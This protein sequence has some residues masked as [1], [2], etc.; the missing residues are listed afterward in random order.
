[1]LILY[2]RKVIYL[3][4]LSLYIYN[5]HNDLKPHNLFLVILVNAHAQMGSDHKLLEAGLKESRE[6]SILENLIFLKKI[7]PLFWKTIIQYMLLN[8]STKV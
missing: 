4:I 5:C 1:M 6:N 2:I 3:N 8:F 7:F